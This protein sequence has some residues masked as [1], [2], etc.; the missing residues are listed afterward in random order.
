MWLLVAVLLLVVVAVA[1]GVV[2]G[3]GWKRAMA[4][5]AERAGLAARAEGL[6]AERARLAGELGAARGHG[7]QMSRR[8][9]SLA[10]EAAEFSARVESL[11]REARA[12]AEERQRE[13]QQVREGYE[14]SL[15]QARESGEQRL[16]EAVA[17][18]RR[19]FD[20][21]REGT[22]KEAAAKLD[23]AAKREADLRGFVAEAEKKLREAF[24]AAAGEQLKAA[25]EGFLKLAEQRLGGAMKQGEGVIE[26]RKAE[27]ASLV[28]PIAETLAKQ[29]EK[30][31]ALEKERAGAHAAIRAQIEQMANSNAMLQRETSQ[32]VQALREPRV[33]GFYGEIQLKRV[34]ELA[35]MRE[36][37]DFVEQDQTVDGEGR[38]LRPDMIVRLP[39]NRH[40]VVD[41]KAN[42]QPYMDAL[43]AGT[44]EAAEACL[45]RFAEGVARQ[46]V[47][48]GKKDYWK[49]YEGSADFVVMFVPGDQFVD[50]AIARRPDL[51]ELAASQRVILASPSTL[52]GLLRAVAV[53]FREE[54]LAKEAEELMKLGRELHERASVAM[55]HVERLGRAISQTVGHYNA[56]VGSYEMRMEPTLKRFAE[57]DEGT[58]NELPALPPVT[59]MV[60]EMRGAGRAEG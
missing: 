47:E 9:E 35:G 37:C 31:A 28:K 54:K 41:A 14:G 16:S 5:E 15:R 12:I 27:V 48:L 32:L 10:A 6:E 43:R 38:R 17:A 40:V 24:G 36:Y 4:A 1:V 29:D 49:Q 7:E 50:A 60:R 13:V 33:R 53:T 23:A 56:F 2:A 22:L 11:E 46:A 30:L 18:A 21:E 8:I 34:A 39:N 52:I 19:E 26:G 58:G 25:S 59:T 3:V 20:R 51:L 44:P 55:G 45:K 57:I 42:I